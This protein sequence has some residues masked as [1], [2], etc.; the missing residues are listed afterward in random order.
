MFTKTPHSVDGVIIRATS[1]PSPRGGHMSGQVSGVVEQ[2]IVLEQLLCRVVRLHTLRT[3]E[4][5]DTKTDHQSHSGDKHS[6]D[7]LNS[8]A[9]SLCYLRRLVVIEVCAG[10]LGLCVLGASL[11]RSLGRRRYGLLHTIH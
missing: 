2:L 8:A 5:L 7:R 10:L 11:P 1:I 4:A 6:S 9:Q 3:D